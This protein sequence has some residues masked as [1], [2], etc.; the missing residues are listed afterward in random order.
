MKTQLPSKIIFNRLTNLNQQKVLSGRNGHLQYMCI[1]HTYYMYTH[2]TTTKSFVSRVTFEKT[3]NVIIHMIR[4][5][6]RSAAVQ[7]AFPSCAELM[8]VI[9]EGALHVTVES[10]CDDVRVHKLARG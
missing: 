9:M 10:T 3:D 5:W 4:F 8:L 7:S 6:G 2:T 1:Y